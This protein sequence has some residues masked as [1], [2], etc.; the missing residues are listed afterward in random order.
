MYTYVEGMY[1]SGFEDGVESGIKADILIAL[2][3]I[4]DETKGVGKITKEKA[5]KTYKRIYR[6]E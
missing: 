3:K 1:R 5:I 4:L 2:I 6:G